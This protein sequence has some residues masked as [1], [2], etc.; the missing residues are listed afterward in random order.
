MPDERPPV[1]LESSQNS[2]NASQRVRVQTVNAESVVKKCA[3]RREFYA[4]CLRTPTESQRPVEPKPP[5]PR[6]VEDSTSTGTSSA[7]VTDAIT[8]C[9][10]RSP[11][12]TW[13]GAWP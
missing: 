4:N 1:V 8:I 10:I 13:N 12:R 5:L 2:P 3:R 9:A 11:R 7:R 6:S